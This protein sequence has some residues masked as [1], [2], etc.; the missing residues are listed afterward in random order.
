[1]N[2]I[3]S[4][5]QLQELY[6]AACQRGE[7]TPTD[8]IERI[9]QRFVYAFS[10]LYSSGQRRIH[11]FAGSGTNGAYALAVARLLRERNYRPEVYLFY[12]QGKL[13]E[14]CETQRQRLAGTEVPMT[15]VSTEFRPPHFQTGELIIDGL[16]GGE[17]TKPLSGGYALVV[18]KINQSGLP[19]VSIEIPSGLYAEDNSTNPLEQVI[20][21][22]HTIAFESPYLALLFG[23]S[24]PYVGQWQ[25]LPIGFDEALHR[26]VNSRYYLQSEQS[27]GMSLLERKP[28]ADKHSY[29]SAL[30]I[31]G[32]TTKVGHLLLTLRAA[33]RS[34]CGEL[35]VHTLSSLAS[36]LQIAQPELLAS[37][38]GEQEF[39]QLPKHLAHYQTIAIGTAMGE[40]AMSEGLF[41][42][43]M[44]SCARPMI[45]DDWAIERFAQ[46]RALLD[47]VPRGSVLL[48]S[49]RD[50]DR[51]F[52][53]QTSS[54]ERVELAKQLAS[55][56]DATI[57]LKGAYTAICR[58][59]DNVYFNTTGNAALA[60]SGS[61]DVL[62]GL[63]LGL[64]TRGY[65]SLIATLLACYLH[66]QVADL[67]AARQSMESVLPS[68]LI[69]HI[70]EALRQLASDN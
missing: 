55:R 36:S 51:L 4:P 9:A 8:L 67:C 26:S 61:G 69:N 31:G 21:A 32:S 53:G 56:L 44:T 13:S 70:G 18:D 41:R 35:T 25:V 60:R 16:F 54:L 63:L 17:L 66:G 40:S 46:N 65:N 14:A 23:E 33:L 22:T 62:T 19:V 10:R 30:L 68:D 52:G 11:I 24:A 38:A 43:L 34:G 2:K 49:R 47:L 27:L 5:L 15:E 59:S 7:L 50:Q 42:Q 58:A 64:M 1:M 29:G 39:E 6:Q 57:V 28:F 37:L 45:F 20:R 48:C 12:R 3:Y